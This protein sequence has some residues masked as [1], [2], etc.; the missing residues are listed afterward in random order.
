AVWF[1]TLVVDDQQQ[2][3]LTERTDEVALVFTSAIAT[4]PAQL[5]AQGGILKA[6]N[7]SRPAYERAAAADLAATPNTRR[8]KQT[9][10]WLRRAADG[11]YTVLAVAGPM[12]PEGDVVT[13]PATR[14]TLDRAMHATSM[15]ATP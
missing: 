1:A 13:D 7:G 3:L 2:R 9:F 15:V 6:T 10:A 11:S 8:N 14:R 4:I 5:S 12:L